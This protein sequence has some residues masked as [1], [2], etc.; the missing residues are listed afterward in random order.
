MPMHDSTI[1][2]NYE[3]LAACVCAVIPGAAGKVRE[4][5]VCLNI[6]SR[7]RLPDI[8]LECGQIVETGV[9][10]HD[11]LAMTRR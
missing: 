9:L 4:V 5:H 3:S 11:G 7:A 10:R 2:C 1:P 8:A 6:E